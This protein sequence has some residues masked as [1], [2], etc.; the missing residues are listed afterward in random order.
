MGKPAGGKEGPCGL[1]GNVAVLA[2]GVLGKAESKGRLHLC[3][4]RDVVR[5]RSLG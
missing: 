2:V 3:L 1:G 4:T 5:A